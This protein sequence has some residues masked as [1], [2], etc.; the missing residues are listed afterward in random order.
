MCRRQRNLNRDRSTRIRDRTKPDLYDRVPQSWY[1]SLHQCWVEDYD[2][3]Y[4]R[5]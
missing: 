4:P 3:M 5:P 1:D 2:A